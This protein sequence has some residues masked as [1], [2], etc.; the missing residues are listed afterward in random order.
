MIEW[1]KEQIRVF[2]EPF[3]HM[4]ID[5]AFGEEANAKIFGFIKSMEDQFVPAKIAEDEIR[6][7]YRDN[8][9]L[10]T[11][12]MFNSSG[13]WLD[14]KVVRKSCPLLAL[15][16]EFIER[17][18]TCSFFGSAPAPVCFFGKAKTWETQISRYGSK[19]FYKWHVDGGGRMNRLISMIYYVNKVP[20]AFKGGNLVL[21]DGLLLNER[22]VAEETKRVEIEPKNDRLV[23]FGSQ[24]LHCVMETDAPKEF[25]DGRFSINIW[26]GL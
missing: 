18:E 24:N 8:L 23:I 1:K 11:D 14:R 17:T 25:A 4:V 13:S 10:Y 20:Q 19:N 15:I 2:R 7:S 3:W 26:V 9:V 6:T 21:S 5:N 22:E 16:D 12:N